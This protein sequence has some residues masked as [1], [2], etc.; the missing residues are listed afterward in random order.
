MKSYSEHLE[1]LLSKKPSHECHRASAIFPVF[2]TRETTMK[3]LFLNYWRIKRKIEHILCRYYIRDLSGNTLYKKCFYLDEARAYTLNLSQ[4]L[5][6]R[7]PF[8]GS[9]EIEFC[10]PENLVFP[11]PAVVV[12]YEGKNFSSFV[13]SAQ[14][15]FND[16]HDEKTNQRSHSIES[17]FNIYS[18]RS[19][20]PFITFVNGS[21]ALSKS[22]IE[23]AAYNHKQKVIGSKIKLSMQ[24]YET[25]YISLDY[26]KEL[27]PHLNNH[28]GTLKVKLPAST[29]FPRILV[30]N[31]DKEM[32][33]MSV[34]HTYYDLIQQNEKDDFWSAPN[35]QWQ[36]AA[37]MLPLKK[38]Q[39]FRSRVFFYPIYSPVPFDIDLEIYTQNGEKVSSHEKVLSISHPEF[40]HIDVN[41]YIQKFDPKKD[42]A[43][44]MIAHSQNNKIPARIKIGFD[45]ESLKGG[46]PCNI[47]TN[48]YPANPDLEKKKQTFR[49]APLMLQGSIWCLNDAPLKNY[50]R[51]ASL[52]LTIYRERDNKTFNRN[53]I[54]LPHNS[55]EIVR[56]Q[57]ISA[58]LDQ[59]I[60]W[61]TIE[62]N[63]PYVTT[64][65]FNEHPSGMIGGD[66]GF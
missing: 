9:L 52:K 18:D 47:C 8:A 16:E 46:L 42:Y 66:H 4:I 2:F 10:S 57:E 30:G 36:A 3:L 33:S 1:S 39:D 54:L 32:E 64:Y 45:V 40:V 38:H 63:N 21:K 44:K 56:D 5:G 61:C 65:Y 29:V 13:H 12:L 24:P 31:R 34:T 17:G 48:F 35:D 7:Y 43:I 26:W 23:L 62:S 51:E 37:L 50:Q 60:G 25:K 11:Y 41:H 14:R 19:R 53:L 55:L 59:E 27:S 6:R 49:W 20:Y 58:F 15:V 22:S 28:V